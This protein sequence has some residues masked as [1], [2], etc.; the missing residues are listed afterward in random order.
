MMLNVETELLI[1]K[2]PAEVFEAWVDPA[3]MARYFISSGT[4]RMEAGK[5]VV[6]SWGDVG[7]EASVKVLEV[8]PARRLKFIWAGFGMEST[9]EATFEPKDGGTRVAVREGAW[10]GDE[11]GIRR[12][13][14]QM[15]G[16]VNMLLCLKAHLV[17]DVDL[18]RG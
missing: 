4:G 12:Y 11:G 3:K 6:W 7:A 10:E 1:A 5:T 9:V 16:W 2:T 14:Q 15:Q 18:R 8:E 17:F 13:G